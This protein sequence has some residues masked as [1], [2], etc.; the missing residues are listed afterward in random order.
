MKQKLAV[1]VYS[2]KNRLAITMYENIIAARDKDIATLQEEIKRLN[3]END[4]LKDSIADAKAY[5]VLS[6]RKK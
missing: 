4:R 1:S 6:R 3:N 5:D 2:G